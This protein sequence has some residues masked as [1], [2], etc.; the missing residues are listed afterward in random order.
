M[1]NLIFLLSL[2]GQIVNAQCIFPS[3]DFTRCSGLTLNATPSG[4]P[5]GTTFSWSAPTINPLGSITGASASG[6]PQSSISFLLSNTS[7]SPATATYVV[8]PQG[9]NCTNPQPFTI[10]VTINPIPV[11]NNFTTVTLCAN[12]QFTGLTL[13]ANIPT[14]S[15]SWNNNNISTGLNPSGSS[16]LPSFTGLNFGPSPNTSTITASAFAN[17]CA[18]PITT[19]GS[20]IINPVPAVIL[21]NNQIVCEGSITQVIPILTNTFGASITWQNPSPE[22]GLPAEG[23]GS[24]I[25]PFTALNPSN[26]PINVPLT[27]VATLGTCS[28]PPSLVCTL[29]VRPMP[30]V[31]L[32][33]SQSVCNGGLVQPIS[34][35][36]PVANTF[37]SN[38]SNSNLLIGL[39][40]SGSG[41]IF[42]FEASNN[43]AI[44]QTAFI[45]ITPQANNCFGV[46]TEVTS[47]TVRPSPT[48]SFIDNDTLCE[49][50][51]FAGKTFQ[52]SL[53]GASFS[54]QATSEFIGIPSQGVGPIPSFTALSPGTSFIQVQ[55]S[56]ANCSF[57]P[58]SF[59]EIKVNPK[60]NFN[61]LT[62]IDSIC[63]GLPTQ[64]NGS[65]TPSSAVVTAWH[66][67]PNVFPFPSPQNQSIPFSFTGNNNSLSPVFADLKLTALSEGCLSD[68][69]F[70]QMSVLPL[71]SVSNMPNLSVCDG[72]MVDTIF[73]DSSIDGS[74]IN[75]QDI[76]GLSGLASEG[77]DFFF[78]AFTA[79]NNADTLLTVPISISLLSAS[80]CAADTVWFFSVL[81]ASSEPD[82]TFEATENNL[83]WSFN[84]I[85][86]S[87]I[88]EIN[89]DFG[90]GTQGNGNPI[91]YIYDTNGAYTVT[92]V[93]TDACGLSDTAQTLV[94]VTVGIP[95]VNTLEEVVIY[96]N[97]HQEGFFIQ[98]SAPTQ[99]E[100]WFALRPDGRLLPFCSISKFSNKLFISTEC[101]PAGIYFLRNFHNPHIKIYKLVK[102][103]P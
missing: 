22:I 34:F 62:Y 32:V 17:G 72:Q 3:S 68:T 5:A 101:W 84:L 11:V 96:P 8:T 99:A 39:P 31:N 71:P 12:Q 82:A 56:E 2:Y 45:T 95:D 87:G 29:T 93:V 40:A 59:F 76:A 103:N 25:A 52:S 98:T 77:N 65:V 46:P 69:F 58:P 18:G 97:P 78:P 24:E 88:A 70:L 66:T 89:W 92:C 23:S 54:W 19:I 9:P 21:T 26:A 79:Q 10:V 30:T 14:A 57:G 43:T 37:F 75:W 94:Q 74:L 48:V 49:E 100:D 83:S 60:P 73:F 13:S 91:D 47:I 16:I 80:G 7:A 42:S 81:P 53:Q 85:N 90:D 102:G 27:A 38:W 55:A 63:S 33:A 36:G 6:T 61:N 41:N 1:R 50:S 44:P 28:S 67:F 64:V 35:S 86:T 4:V 20:I 15:I 51:I